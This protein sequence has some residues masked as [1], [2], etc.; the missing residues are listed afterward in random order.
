MN[1]T[2]SIDKIGVG[3]FE[4]KVIYEHYRGMAGLNTFEEKKL[5]RG[6]ISDC[7]AIIEAD[8]KGYLTDAAREL[9][10]K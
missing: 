9:A 4:A 1:K 8:K 10:T 7:V 3:E 5:F 2:Y 6:S